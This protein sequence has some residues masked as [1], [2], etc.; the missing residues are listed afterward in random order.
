MS[1]VAVAM[2]Y[3]D[4]A[5]MK[6]VREALEASVMQ[7][8]GVRSKGMMGCLVYFRDR[9]FFAFLVTNGLVITKLTQEEREELSRK[10]TA[11]PFEMA[12]RTSSNWAQVP[13]RTPGD[14]QPVL[15]YVRKS[16][17][18]IQGGE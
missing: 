7:W 8:P 9:K 11:K 5:S 3:Y 16:Y 4:E 14:L 1:R 12:G 15:F 13:A 18:A 2:K 17:E 10:V 6:E